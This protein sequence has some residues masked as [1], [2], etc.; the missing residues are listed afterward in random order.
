MYRRRHRLGDYLQLLQKHGLVTKSSLMPGHFSRI[1]S[2]VS[3]NSQEEMTDAIFI[4]KGAHFKE[5]YLRDAVSGGAFCYVSEVSYPSIEGTSVII[6]SNV[7][8]AM[9]L[10]ADYYYNQVWKQLN[11]IGITGTKG[12]SSTTYY[13]KYILDEYLRN[14]GQKE[15]GIISSIDTYDGINRFESHLTTPESLDLHRHFDNAVQSGISYLEMEVSSQGLKYDRVA[16]IQ[17]DVGCYLNLGLDHISPL[18]HP[19]EEDYFQSKLKLFHQCTVACVNLDGPRADEV[20]KAARN[21]QKIITFGMQPAADVYGYEVQKSG[22][23]IVFRART[24]RF[25]RQFRL[26]MPGLFNVENALAAI[27]ISEAL[28]IPERY[29]YI[30][31]MKARVPGRMEIYSNANNR[32]IAIV[33]Y[34]HNRLSF[35]KLFQSVREEYPDRRI[36][37][38]FG[39][40]G[41][42]ALD[43]RR[44]LGEIS[45]R[46]SNKVIL[47]EEDAGEEPV[48]QICQEIAAYVAAENCDYSILPDRGEAIETAVLEC[49]SP[50]VLL[51]TGKGNETRQK[52]G[53]AYVPCPSDVEYV[54]SALHRYDVL[55]HLDDMEKAKAFMSMLPALKRCMGKTYVVKYGGSALGN[56]AISDTI[57]ADAAALRM[58]GANV[59]L[60][61]GGGKHISAWL[62]R[63]GVSAQFLGGYRVTDPDTMSVAEMTLSGLVNKTIVSALE[64]LGVSAAGVSGRDGGLLTA[65]VKSSPNGD[66]GR[67]GTLSAVNTRLLQVLLEAGYL[68]VVSPVANDAG[69][70]P[71]NINADDAACAIAEALSADKLIFL[72]DTDGILVDARNRQTRIAQMDLARANELI[73]SGFVGGGMLPKLQNCVHA[74]QH[75]VSKVVI[76]DGQSE[77]SLLLESISQNSIGTTIVKETSF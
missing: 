36:V 19:D 22:N 8:Q 60:V 57:L 5:A 31:L 73:E 38:V 10:L 46:Y 29:I 40:P 76:L 26:T 54:K 47:T 4:C 67:V 71:L 45:G 6:V 3:C 34:A 63:M 65:E 44:D 55:H 14:K 66:L 11:L 74:V 12:K 42:K 77:H 17:F 72:T 58:A 7:R 16:N 37:T 2:T 21:C 25:S 24:A 20:L 28:G 27:A 32:V 50:S 68:P 23:D 64:R 51:I 62:S 1:I 59:V 52:R 49:E 48:E 30:G 13:V 61:H 35:E 18:E 9:A 53:T 70:A 33:D 39:C 56:E 43:R 15:S 69:G 75:S 41:F